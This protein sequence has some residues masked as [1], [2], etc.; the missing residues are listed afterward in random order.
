MIPW[1]FGSNGVNDLRILLQMKANDGRFIHNGYDPKV[2][3]RF[4]RRGWLIRC[5]DQY[6]Q[7]KW[8]V[9]C[10]LA[11][12]HT[13]CKVRTEW[14]SDPALFKAALFV[15]G[16]MYLMSPQAPRKK[17]SRPKGSRQVA[18][19]RHKGGASHTLEAAFFKM[20]VTWC[21]GMREL[22][23]KYGLCEWIPRQLPVKPEEA[24]KRGAAARDIAL[25]DEIMHNAGRFFMKDGVLMENVTS[26]IRP[27]VDFGLHIPFEHRL[28]VKNAY[29]VL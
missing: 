14:L 3:N 6:Y 29:C 28:T 7:V 9:I 8:E 10:P 15:A 2:L 21:V 23:T 18:E 4:V 22:A 26:E 1:A 12:R 11:G 17:T 25:G 5:K 16:C 27:L 24:G 20:S 13:H 19:S